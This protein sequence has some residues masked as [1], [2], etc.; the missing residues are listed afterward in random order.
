[1]LLSRAATV[2]TVLL[3]CSLL[4][5]CSENEI[6]KLKQKAEQAEKLLSNISEFSG[7]LLLKNREL[8]ALEGIQPPRPEATKRLAGE[9]DSEQA[10]LNSLRN[11]FASLWAEINRE[12]KDLSEGNLKDALE[13]IKQN[14]PLLWE[15]YDKVH[16]SGLGAVDL[17]S[18]ATSKLDAL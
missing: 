14:L 5:G 12:L 15:Y 16:G 4:T 11:E 10:L 6:N 2:C 7:K 8:A 13:W 3:A 18:Q 17:L 9:I 1:M